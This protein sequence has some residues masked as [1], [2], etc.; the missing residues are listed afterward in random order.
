MGMCP[1]LEEKSMLCVLNAY[2]RTSNKRAVG[3]KVLGEK[4]CKD[5]LPVGWNGRDLCR[6][7]ERGLEILNLHFL[8]FYK[9]RNTFTN[10]ETYLVVELCLS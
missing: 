4:I 8:K 3:I 9:I 6:V 1:Q 10:F 5:K 7:V 2:S